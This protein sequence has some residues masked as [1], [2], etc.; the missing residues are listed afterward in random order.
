VRPLGKSRVEPSLTDDSWWVL[1]PEER[2]GQQLRK[3]GPRPDVER[4]HFGILKGVVTCHAPC[5][6]NPDAATIPAAWILR[7]GWCRT[8]GQL[9]QQPGARCRCAVDGIGASHAPC[10]SSPAATALHAID[11]AAGGL[12]V[13]LDG[14]KRKKKPT[15]REC[16]TTKGR[17]LNAAHEPLPSRARRWRLRPPTPS[18]PRVRPTVKRA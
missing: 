18:P 12:S 9:S 8:A 11:T 17:P 6:T 4:R 3:R 16:D 13:C 7:S 2:D 14:I 5:D 10:L 15:E 1:L